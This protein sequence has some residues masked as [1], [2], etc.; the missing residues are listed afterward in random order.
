MDVMVL[1]QAAGAVGLFTARAF[2]PAFLA[3][4]LMRWGHHVPIVGGS[5][6]IQ[7]VGDLP[8]WFTHDI[9]IIVLGVL[10]ALE[11]AAQHSAEA[12]E[13][14]EQVSGYA[15][16]GMAI[17]TTLGVA[18]AADIGFVEGVTQ[19]AAGLGD[20][21]VAIAIGAAVFGLA[22]LRSQAIAPLAEADEEDALGLQSLWAW[23][24]DVWASLGVV[25]VIVVPI[26]VAVVTLG[27]VGVL[28][29]LR[30]RA[31]IREEKAKEPCPKCETARPIHASACPSC[32]QPVAEPRAVGFFGQPMS[33][34]D[35]NPAEH[36]LAL[37][38]KRRCPVC[39]ARL[40]ERRPRQT[41][42]ACGEHVFA[43][44]AT[45]GA[46]LRRVQRRLGP[47]L[48]F[49]AAVG[50][51]PVLGLIAGLIAYRLKLVSPLSRYLPRRRAFVRK[52]GLRVVLLVLG[53]L[54]L[55]PFVGAITVPAMAALSYA[56][57]RKAFV[58]TL[59]E[60]GGS[61]SAAN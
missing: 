55:A 53:L 13:L 43:D 47:T 57:Y 4:V 49:C 26:V 7:A 44:E 61:A 15:K 18:D 6:L 59:A 46:Y 11:I 3:A 21:G 38:E 34:A 16:T 23:V 37:L 27:I 36:G 39:A 45:R 41:C 17:A 12:R 32:R 22:S 25:L 24:E 33:R 31:R 5:E 50:W 35:A 52:L 54:Q 14:Y 9:T 56:V 20:T 1:L 42:A 58:K 48:A 51:I 2:V 30:R 40:A 28:L 19:Q 10:A 60:S 8:S 29:L